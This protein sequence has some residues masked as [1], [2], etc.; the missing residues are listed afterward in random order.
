MHSGG[1]VASRTRQASPA[2]TP[3]IHK[4]KATANLGRIRNKALIS[5]YQSTNPCCQTVPLVQVGGKTCC[6][7]RT[8]LPKRAPS[9]PRHGV[10]ARQLRKWQ[11]SAGAGSAS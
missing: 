8:T 3:E 5:I 2:L 1:G 7:N 9:E 6:R 4:A 11:S 10:E